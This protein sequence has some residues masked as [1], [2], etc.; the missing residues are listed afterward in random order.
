M[1]TICILFD[2]II[3]ESIFCS[4]SFLLITAIAFLS[5]NFLSRF[6]SSSVSGQLPSKT[7]IINCA[8]SSL[9]YAIFT[10]IPSITS[11]VSLMPAVSESRKVRSPIF[12][13]S[14]ITSR[15]VPAIS[16]TILLS[17]PLRQ[18]KSVDFPTFGR[19][20]ITVS[21]PSRRIL[22]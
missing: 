1:Y 14:S 18:L 17:Q 2:F 9:L 19:P 21:I 6:I 15:V 5:F 3:S 13:D 11:S 20:I 10:P 4:T 12:T 16:V 7:A 8:S 22:P